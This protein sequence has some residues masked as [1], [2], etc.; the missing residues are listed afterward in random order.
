MAAAKSNP[1]L[2]TVFIIYD[3]NLDWCIIV[4]S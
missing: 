2:A 1:L 4:W 3:W